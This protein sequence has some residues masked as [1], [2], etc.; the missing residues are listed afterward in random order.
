MAYTHE[1][2][3]IE[4]EFSNDE[5]MAANIVAFERFWDL[6]IDR[7]RNQNQLEQEAA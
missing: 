2:T 4:V 3:Q 7:L 5:P 1:P 6:V